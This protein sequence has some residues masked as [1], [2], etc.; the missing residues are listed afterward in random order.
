MS[1]TRSLSLLQAISVVSAIAI[2]LWTIGVP[3]LRSAEAA[4]VIEFSDVVSDSAPSVGADH[5]LTFTT[6]TGLAA[7]NDIVLT[8]ADFDFTG[9]TDITDLSLSIGGANKT[10]AG[11]AS[12]AVWGAVI[13]GGAK[14]ITLTSGSDVVASS[15]EIVI[16]VGDTNQIIN[17]ATSSVSYQITVEM[18]GSDTGTTMVAI[19]DSVKVTASVET[20]F[21]FYIT[22]FDASNA[23]TVNGMDI[24]GTSTPNTIDFGTVADGGSVSAAQGFEVY[25]NAKNGFVVTVVADQ[26]LTSANGAEIASFIE[27]SAP[28]SPTSWVSTNP[29]IGVANT[30]GHWGVSAPYSNS[31]TFASEEHMA[32]PTNPAN[33]LEVF[34]HDG[35][36]DGSTDG[37]GIANVVYTVEVSKLQPAADDYSATLTYVATPTF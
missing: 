22:G 29:T 25:T 37:V 15:T 3:S 23:A 31:E 6:P 1:I 2:V 36:A 30:Y 16:T 12:G 18:E 24:V 34:S 17:P 4:N 21:E 9:F 13:N 28:A 33:A 10:L 14:T 8:F 35:P 19:V 5:T 20:S 11:T 26:T 7:G 27:G 32:I